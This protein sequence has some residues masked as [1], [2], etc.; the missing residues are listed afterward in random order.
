MV[1]QYLQLQLVLQ[2]PFQS[3]YQERMTVAGSARDFIQF[4]A[5]PIVHPMATHLYAIYFRGPSVHL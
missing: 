2:Q 5:R 3:R 1:G 4:M